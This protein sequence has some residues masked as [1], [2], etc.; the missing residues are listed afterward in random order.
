MTNSIPIV[1]STDNNYVMPTGVTIFS[2][3]ESAKSTTVYNIFVIINEDV[4]DE[5]KNLLRKQVACFPKH[6]IEFINIGK[7]FEDSFK[8]R[9]ISVATYSRLLIPWLLPQ[10]D[11]IIFSDVD[12]IF[13]IDLSEVYNID[14]AEKLVAGVIG[15]R[16]RYNHNDVK[17]INSIGLNVEDYIYAGFLVINSKLQREQD[18]INSYL[19]EA[20]KNYYFQDMDIINIVC[21]N[22]IIHLSPAYCITPGFYDMLIS[23]DPSFREFYENPNYLPQCQDISKA[24]DNYKQGEECILHYAGNKPWNTFTQGWREW[25]NAYRNSIFYDPDREIRVSRSILRPIPSWREMA[26][27]LKRKLIN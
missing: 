3:L 14:M 17:Y 16:L 9:D 1:F 22:R 13:R 8:I 5:N 24:I 11:K 4:T 27:Q 18:L 2:L 6:T 7:I 19:D 25:W 15:H 20:K 21:K 10:Y 26:R 12:V 23:K